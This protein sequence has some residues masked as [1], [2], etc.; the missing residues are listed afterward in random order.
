MEKK[1]IDISFRDKAYTAEVSLSH[2]PVNEE[3]MSSIL[4]FLDYV[5]TRNDVSVV[6]RINNEE[7]SDD[8]P[9]A[10]ML[11]ESDEGFYMELEYSEREPGRKY[12][13]LLANDHLTEEE[14]KTVLISIFQECTDQI[15]IIDE[16]FEE[17]SAMVY[18]E[19]E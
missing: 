8:V 18:S 12:P 15:S 11:A 19:E 2:L 5:R 4:S 10:V 13:R 3:Q 16:G 7:Y 17:I 6:I 1:S 14:A 9:Q